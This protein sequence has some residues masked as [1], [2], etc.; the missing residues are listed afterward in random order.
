M[1]D[2]GNFLSLVE[3]IGVLLTT[4]VNL[5]ELKEKENLIKK[6]MR[7]VNP[8]QVL[9]CGRFAVDSLSLLIVL[10]MLSKFMMTPGR[11][12][13]LTTDDVASILCNT[14]LIAGT[15]TAMSASR[16]QSL[17]LVAILVTQYIRPRSIINFLQQLEGS[18]I[19]DSQKIY[20][21]T[22]IVL[23]L[24][25]PSSSQALSE[26]SKLLEAYGEEVFSLLLHNQQFEILEKWI[27][28]IPGSL[29]MGSSLFPVSSFL[30]LSDY[31]NLEDIMVKCCQK[32]DLKEYLSAVAL[33]LLCSDQS[34]Y[35]VTGLKFLA[36][37]L[38]RT[39][40]PSIVVHR[41]TQIL[42]GYSSG[43]SRSSN[44]SSSSSSSSSGSSS[45]SGASIVDMPLYEA[46]VCL[47]E[48][49]DALDRETMSLLVL[50][51]AFPSG[52]ERAY[53]CLHRKDI[54]DRQQV[55]EEDSNDVLRYNF[56]QLREDSRHVCMCI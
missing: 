35:Q 29:I 56:S 2:L 19:S 16:Y 47:L 31:L 24:E 13:P 49:S 51:S 9:Q 46:I 10:Q 38:K 40:I 14:V 33:E 36:A 8:A 27:D 42:Q 45:G 4:T 20:I 53:P 30:P 43:H 23:S 44:S 55:N 39:R 28:Y 18:V 5:P 37:L 41:L 7:D 22:E 52:V 25:A 54:I 21:L 32:T 11:L 15:P 3:R 17:K 6:L 34:E 48:E 50:V 26:S 12:S 1:C